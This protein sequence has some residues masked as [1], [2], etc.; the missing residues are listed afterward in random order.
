MFVDASLADPFAGVLLLDNPI[1][2]WAA[3]EAA[4]KKHFLVRTM[5]DDTI[6]NGVPQ[7]HARMAAA[8]T[9]FANAIS[10]DHPIETADAPGY[11]L[12]LTGGTPS[13]CHPLA[14][15][16]CKSEDIESQ[17]RLQPLR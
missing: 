11:F 17:D 15:K 14:P 10:T 3:I 13:R 8:V 12:N 16:S 6:V 1:N 7:S 9:S 2:D 4:A 5:S